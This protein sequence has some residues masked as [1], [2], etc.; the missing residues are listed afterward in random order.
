[1]LDRDIQAR[2]LALRCLHHQVELARL[3]DVFIR[4]TE[5]DGGSGLPSGPEPRH[6]A[7]DDDQKEKKRKE[8]R[9]ATHLLMMND[10]G[11]AYKVRVD[12]VVTF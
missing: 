8:L 5:L 12:R 3:A 1:L 9:K 4:L 2:E 11:G 10:G 6:A 7:A